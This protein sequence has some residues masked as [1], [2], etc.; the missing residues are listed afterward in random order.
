MDLLREK[1]RAR[2]HHCPQISSSKSSSS[3]TSNQ[4]D[5]RATAGA[6]GLAVSGSNNMVTNQVTDLGAVQAGAE[7]AR[8]AIALSVVS[9]D[10]SAA[11]TRAV[12][13]EALS[14][15]DKAYET[16]KA[17]DQREVS[18][19]AMAAVVMVAAVA[20]PALFKKG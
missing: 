16:S 4:Y 15:V 14:S 8:R 10:Q 9:A 1:L 13:S 11:N 19:V 3:T 17:G 20:V 18:M 7:M 6:A 2:G 5:Q 12:F